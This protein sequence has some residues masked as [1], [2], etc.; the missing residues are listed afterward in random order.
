MILCAPILRWPPYEQH[1]L[2]HTIFQRNKT[3]FTQ[4]CWLLRCIYHIWAFRNR[5]KVFLNPS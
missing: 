4:P 5:A 3:I 1:R 2:L